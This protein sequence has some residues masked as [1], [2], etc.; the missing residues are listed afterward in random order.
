M[1]DLQLYLLVA[2]FVLLLVAGAGVLWV[3][4]SDKAHRR[5]H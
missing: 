2:P 5:S 1:T 3:V 4:K